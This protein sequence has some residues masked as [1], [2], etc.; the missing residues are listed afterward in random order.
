MQMVRDSR[1]AA[2]PL[3]TGGNG[4]TSSQPGS[5]MPL[6]IEP[7]QSTCWSHQ[8]RNFP[9]AAP[10]TRRQ[11]PPAPHSESLKQAL[12]AVVP[13]SQNFGGPAHK[14]PPSEPVTAQIPPAPHSVPFEQD[15][16]ALQLHALPTLAPATHLPWQ[17]APLPRHWEL[18][19]QARPA[20]S[21]LAPQMP[22]PFES[23]QV[24]AGQSAFWAHNRCAPEPGHSVGL[25]PG[26]RHGRPPF[27]PPVAHRGVQALPALVPPTQRRGGAVL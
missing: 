1:Q 21:L 27:A 3:S 6:Q 8:A 20:L 5:S 23:V 16:P 17:R 22:G 2:L 11:M 7:G 19:K 9:A 25:M 12:P 24:P 15:E 4:A 14:P 18:S 10:P 13:P 26:I